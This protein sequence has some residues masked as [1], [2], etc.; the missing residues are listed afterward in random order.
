LGASLPPRTFAGFVVA[1]L[2]VVALALFSFKV[3][4]APARPMPEAALARTR[5][6]G[7]L[8]PAELGRVL[9]HLG[10]PSGAT[11]ELA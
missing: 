2:A 1:V 3:T 4:R 7:V 10:A 5:V 8:P 9:A 11:T 6:D